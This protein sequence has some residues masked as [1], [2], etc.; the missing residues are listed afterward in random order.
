M[1]QRKRAIFFVFTFLLSIVG[2][3]CDLLQSSEKKKT[4]DTLIIPEYQKL[5]FINPLL[6]SS[7]FSA[8]L[9]E[10]IFD[11]LI[12]LDDHFEVK[13]HIAESWERSKDGMTWTFHLRHGITFH[14][15]VEL[16]AE[17]V[18]YTFQM[19]KENQGRIPF[20]F[21]F[22]DVTAI[23][24]KDK[25]TVQIRLRK[26]IASFLQTLFMG[27]LPKHILK[28]QNLMTAPFNQRPIGTG[29]FNLKSWTENEIILEA[30]HSYFLGRPYLNQIHVMV[31]PN[32]EAAWAKL[33]AGEVDFFPYLTPENYEVLKQI[34][35]FRFYSIPM[36]FYYLVAFNLRE[37]IFSDRRVRQALNYAINKDE[38]VGTV[39]RGQGQVAAGTIFPGSWAFNPDI[40]PYPYNPQ[41]ALKLLKEAG[42]GDHDQDHFLDKE[43]RPFEFTVHVNA[44]DDV[45]EKALLLIQ[46][47]LMD[48]GIKMK[49]RVFD[50]ATL[51][52]LFKKQ[53]Q[54]F[55][56]EIVARGDPD[57]SY[58]YWH[59]SQIKK[60]FNVSSYHNFEV[61][62]LLEAG[63]SEFD[64]ERRKAI[65][66]SFQ[67]EL[68][69]DPPGIFLFWTN[70]LV[71]IH[72]RFKGVRISP[73]SPFANI[74]EWYV[75]KAEQRYSASKS[76]NE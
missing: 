6:T 55:F 35:T 64:P 9:S 41:K 17:D 71:G 70:Y 21:V 14:D 25:Y 2:V 13:P 44:G 28:G 8:R 48:V 49:I 27:I 53:F 59:S 73:V 52:F 51:E 15:G 20:A 42:W 38:I 57:F 24:A 56:P 43:G 4:G 45:K 76:L 37:R 10:V 69:K 72:Q 32:Q 58:T 54:A 18:A 11:S 26:P 12:Q 62:R 5:A 47:H 74:R 39:L 40:K 65:Y 36:P 67:E 68:L 30:N 16:T 29:P 3:S 66:F 23:E 7:T 46:Q 31:Y 50:A 63:R 33:M 19:I 22:Q 1:P 60:G 34:P 61:D 75:P